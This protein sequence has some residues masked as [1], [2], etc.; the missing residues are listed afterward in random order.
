ME[1]TGHPCA[2]CMDGILGPSGYLSIGMSQL[3]KTG[4]EIVRPLRS[5]NGRSTPLRDRPLTGGKR[6]LPILRLYGRFTL[7]ADVDGAL[8]AA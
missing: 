2:I 8:L 5:E 6:S 4:N 3:F 1:S 7:F